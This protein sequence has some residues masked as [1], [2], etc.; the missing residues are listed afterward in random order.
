VR[1]AVAALG[2]RGDVVPYVV[3]GRALQAGGHDVLIS[4]VERFRAMV[5]AAGLGFHALPGDPADAAGAVLLD[6]SLWRPIR[7]VNVLHAAVDALVRQTDPGPLRRRW[8]DRDHIIFTSSTTFARFVADDLGVGSAM[9]TMT[10]AVATGAFP[11]AVLLPGL[12]LGAH[13][14]LA[15]W[16]A[17]ERLQRQMFQE[18]LKPSARRAWGLPPSP[19]STD[20][21]GAGWPRFAVVHAFSPAVVPKPGDWPGHV[22]VTGWLLPEPSSEPLPEPVERF[23][24]AGEAPVYVGFGS[25]PVPEPEATGRM[26]VAALRRTGQRAIVCGA[27]LAGTSALRD[28]DAVVAVDELPHERLLPRVRA[29]VHHGGSGTT[30][31]GLRAGRP[32]LITPFIFDQF[33]WGRRVHK[34]GAGPASIPFGRLSEDRLTR[35]LAQLTSGRHDAAAQDLGHRI[36]AED[37]AALAVREIE[38]LSDPA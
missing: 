33:F 11:H 16:L 21:R 7:H 34:L 26:L 12:R 27:A 19:L 25:M 24:A 23:L 17:G 32:T 15:S 10:P 18:P 29:V 6:V 3:L 20:R 28:S 35:A 2:T 13:A 8:A 30:G 31:A 1:F 38:R 9:V 4:T 22:S 37:P 36:R 14:N 5:E